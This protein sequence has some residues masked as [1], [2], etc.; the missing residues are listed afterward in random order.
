LIGYI[1]IENF[2]FYHSHVQ[3]IPYRIQ[4]LLKGQMD[5]FLKVGYIFISRYFL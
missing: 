1:L 2:N 4:F 5:I 3:D